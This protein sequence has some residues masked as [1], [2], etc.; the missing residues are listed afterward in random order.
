MRNLTATRFRP[1][2]AGIATD[3]VQGRAWLRS[4]RSQEGAGLPMAQLKL[5]SFATPAFRSK[6]DQRLG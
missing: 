6:A 4:Q 3:V 5:G 1:G 2:F